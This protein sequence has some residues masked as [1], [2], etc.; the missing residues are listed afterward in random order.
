[1]WSEARQKKYRKIKEDPK[2]LNFGAVK[3]EIRGP[4][5]Q[6]DKHLLPDQGTSTNPECAKLRD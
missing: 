1:M 5:T 2:I 6:L 3:P 4:G